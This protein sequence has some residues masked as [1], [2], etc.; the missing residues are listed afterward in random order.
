MTGRDDLH[1]SAAAYA[2]DALPDD[3]RAAF[4]AHLTTCPACV[5]E[6]DTLRTTAAHLAEPTT[7]PVPHTLREHVLA[8]VARTPQLPPTAADTAGHTTADPRS[9]PVDELGARRR[10]RVTPRWTAG[11]AA[12]AVLV[13]AIGGLSYL[14]WDLANRLDASRAAAEQ[15]RDHAERLLEVLAAPDAT[16]VS[17]GDAQGIPGTLVVSVARGEAMFV[18]DD[19]PAPP[20]ERTY[21]MWLIGEDGATPAGEFDPDPL[22]R[23][24]HL[25]SGDLATTAAVGVTIEPLGGSPQPTTD[26]VLVLELG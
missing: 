5:A 4:E 15:A 20:S 10:T 3:E 21:Q 2:L 11:V 18:A 7:A 9:V 13:M 17:A 12:A 6:V 16:I 14:S 23:A 19:L 8:E 1:L 24:S 25:V 22:G 26:P